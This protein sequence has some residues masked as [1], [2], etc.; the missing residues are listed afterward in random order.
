MATQVQLRSFLS[1]MNASV[2][3]PV[4]DRSVA[5]KSVTFCNRSTVSRTVESFYKNG[6][7]TE[8]N[9]NIIKSHTVHVQNYVCE[10][11]YM[12]AILNTDMDQSCVM[13]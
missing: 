11:T 9:I 5:H 8:Q 10:C 12:M 7:K 4:S 3:S 13:T 1:S 6:T 2:V